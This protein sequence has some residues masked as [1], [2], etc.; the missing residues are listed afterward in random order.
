LK[1]PDESCGEREA[2]SSSLTCSPRCLNR[3]QAADYCGCGS[4]STFDDW[5]RRGILPSPITGTR[6]WDRKAID[7]ALDKRSGLSTKALGQEDPFVVWE[8]EYEARKAV[9]GAR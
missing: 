7:A 3:P 9:A 1:Y 2:A 5:V 6:R 8:R 4:L